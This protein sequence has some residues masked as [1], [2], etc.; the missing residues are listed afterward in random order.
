M[1]EHIRSIFGAYSGEVTWWRGLAIR[2]NTQ[3]C[4]DILD[5]H[6]SRRPCSYAQ[7]CCSPR[8]RRKPLRS[9]AW[10]LLQ[11]YSWREEGQQTNTLANTTNMPSLTLI[12][13]HGAS[14]SSTF[15]AA[16]CCSMCRVIFG[17]YSGGRDDEGRWG[18]AVRVARNRARS[19]IRRIRATP[20]ALSHLSADAQ[21]TCAMRVM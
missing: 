7:V 17:A 12:T 3:I 14:I 10:H 2:V 11:A 16:L 4:I 13:A 8:E 1:C 18:V 5:M 15:M 21:S 9:C 20:V 19:L 6:D